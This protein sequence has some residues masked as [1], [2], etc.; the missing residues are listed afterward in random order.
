[1]A[2][3][4]STMLFLDEAAI[5]G[6]SGLQRVFA[7]AST[8]P[9]NPIIRPTQSWEMGG[10]Y[11]FGSII[12]EPDTGGFRMWYQAIDGGDIS[13]AGHMSICYAESDDGVHWRKPLAPRMSHGH[14]KATNIVLG[15][16][17]YAGNPYCASVIR[18]ADAPPA[19]RYK[20]AAWFEQWSDRLS[21]F[22]GAASFH[23]P[24]G[25]HWQVYEGAEPFIE[26]VH[27]RPNPPGYYTL[28][29]EYWLPRQG[30]APAEAL[31]IGGP[32]DAS[33]I[34][35][36]QLDGEYVHFQVMQRKA[37]EG[38]R[39]YERDLITG[40]ERFIAMHTSPDFVHWSHPR[41]IIAPATEDP[42]YIQFYGMG[43][44]RYGN[45]WLGVLWMYYVHDQSMDLE[46]AISR[47][48]RHWSRPFPGQRLVALG[49]DDAFDCGMI[50]SA[51]APVIAGD[52]IYIYY[53]GEDHRHDERGTAAIGLAT[54]PLDRWAGMLAG[55]Q[56]MLQT[57][58][59]GFQGEALEL[60]AYAHGGEVFAEI[61]DEEG[62]VLA[63]YDRDQSV[64]LV[65]DMTHGRLA[66]RS[67]AG[68]SVLHGKKIA[69]R[70][71]VHNA[72]IYALT[73]V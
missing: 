21:K 47:D 57:M 72:T 13:T 17:I 33:C 32:N 63:G 36:D 55:R 54:L 69:V 53:G 11:T 56:G 7:P 66:W 8:H 23:S 51:T 68:L 16:S 26:E 4:Q 5:A 3:R 30:E 29:G 52:Q 12:R 15:H 70:L 46:L 39:S 42:D 64:P 14:R 24:D 61:L 6:Q 59:F 71:I 49:K 44:F 10:I 65:G 40:R 22:D 31:Y 1:M 73:Q 25:L 50:M 43:G 58:P 28:D 19:E 38:K 62:R 35:P 48:G 20:M 67:G 27:W 2:L 41:T 9:D 45:Y 34:S 18:D 60:N 37:P